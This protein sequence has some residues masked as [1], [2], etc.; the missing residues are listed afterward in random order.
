MIGYQNR[1]RDWRNEQV[2]ISSVYGEPDVRFKF[3]NTS[4]YGTRIWIDNINIGSTLTI[5]GNEELSS[6][7]IYP[8]P[9]TDVFNIQFHGQDNGSRTL[10]L[11]NAIGQQ[12]WKG[13][14]P[15]GTDMIEQIDISDYEIGVYFLTV[16]SLQGKK[17]FKLVKQ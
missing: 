14:L 7:S 11:I 13:Q 12:I 6:I 2:D 8:N 1:N 5:D 15:S 4:G 10:T 9:S 17:T 3:Q 16:E